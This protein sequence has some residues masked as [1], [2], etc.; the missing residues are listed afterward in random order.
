MQFPVKQL[1]ALTA[2]G[3][4]TF[5]L[6]FPVAAGAQTVVFDSAE[7]APITVPQ[8]PTTLPAEVGGV[9]EERPEVLPQVAERPEGAEVAGNQL[10]VTGT[11]ALGLSVIGLAAIG[12]GAVMLRMRR[13]NADA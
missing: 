11:D 5:A 7:T 1:R 12:A 3:V 9:Q 6:G 4:I 8:V 2:A 10:A 13:N